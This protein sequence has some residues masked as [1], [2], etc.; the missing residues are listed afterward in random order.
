MRA[1]RDFSIRR[2]LTT[3]SM[4][5][6][7]L[8]LL[9]AGAAFIGYDFHDARESKVLDLTT[10]ANVLGSNSAAALVFNDASSAREMLR[11]LGA[12]P[13]VV[14]ACL[15]APSGR[16][17]AV[18]TRR[19]TAAA[20][21]WPPIGPEGARF[22]D[23]YL[24]FFHRITL[25]LETVGTIYLEE[26]SQDLRDRLA[27][28]T[29]V[30]GVVLL[31]ASFGAFLL[32]SK[33][34]Q[35]ISAPIQD[36]ARTTR[37][38]STEKNY[39]VRASKQGEDE[40]GLLIEGFN[41]MLEQIQRR[42]AELQDARDSLERRVKDRTAELQSQIAERQRAEE[43]LR[44]SD[45]RTR[46]LLDS[47]G[48]G[49]YGLDTHGNCTFCNPACVRTLG[50][51]NAGEL[52]GRN[53]HTLIHHSRPGGASLPEQDCR[54]SS[55][56]RRG[57]G[58]HVD[59][60]V[61]WRADG[62]SFPVEY[63]SHPIRRSSM[64]VGAVVT[65]TD[66]TERKRAEQHRAL[67]HSVAGILAASPSVDVAIPEI[68]KALCT[69]TG[70]E[71]GALFTLDPSGEALRPV[72]HWSTDERLGADFSEEAKPLLVPRGTGLAGRAW[73]SGEAVWAGDLREVRDLARPDSRERLGL[74]AAL[75]FPIFAQNRVTGVLEFFSRV[76]SERD[77]EVIGVMGGLGSQVGQFL[78]RKAAESQLE[79]AKE[80]AEA[81][82]RAK[83]EFLANMS[84]EI[85]TPMN[86]VLGLTELLLD[87]DLRPDQREYLTLVQSS[88]ESLL[89]IINDVLDFSKI[90]AG[91]ID[92]DRIEFNLRDS[93]ADVLKTLAVRAHKKG[94]ELSFRVAPDL[95]ERV[96]GDPLRLRQIIINLVGNAIKFTEHGEVNLSVDP[97]SAA[98]G[99]VRLHWVVSDTGIGISPQQQKTIFEPFTQADSS[100]TRRYGGT[101]LGLTISDRL[102]RMMDGGLWVESALGQGSRFHFTLVL[103]CAADPA[104]APFPAE[105]H[106][107]EN[108]PVLVVDDNG[109]NRLILDEMLTRAGF[110]VILADGGR[111]ALALLKAARDEGKP[112]P[113]ILLDGHMPEMDGF[114]V[115]AEIRC[116]LGLTGATI[117]M[118]TS[119]QQAADFL[120]CRELGIADCLTKPIGQ[121]D[122]FEAIQRVLNSS[123][124]RS[125][126]TPRRT[127]LP[128]AAPAERLH[129]LL[130]EDNTVN[131]EYASRL[132]EKYGHRVTAAVNGREVLAVLGKDGFGAFDA[133]L[134]DVQMPEMDGL[135]ATAAIRERERNQGGHLPIIAM[136]AHALKGDRERCLAAGMDGY[137][138]KPV[139]ADMLFKELEA[140]IRHAESAPAQ[141]AAP[142]PS[143]PSGP[144][145]LDRAAVLTLV[146][147]DRQLLEQLVSIFLDEVPTQLAGLK[148]AIGDGDAPRVE[149]LAHT[150]KG[151]IS[152]FAASSAWEAAR[153]LETLGREKNLAG[154]EAALTSLGQE[155]ERLKPALQALAQEVPS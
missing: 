88:A 134:M 25:Q 112:I 30:L 6:T 92:L 34:Q 58:A 29:G 86:G 50:Y 148:Q 45:E 89:Q 136:T 125:A 149:R 66:I 132:L 138:S 59:D 98:D 36:L 56:F 119:D 121:R 1:F 57:E 110:K 75:A 84:H 139:R 108:L 137:V 24:D 39:S 114:A 124:P 144:M 152:N 76:A 135:E 65:F 53:L 106:C 31:L 18:Y 8:A 17:F 154:A 37:T 51:R 27:R 147:G 145:L 13:Q 122:L 70:W 79:Q 63:R 2:K 107:L 87:T 126:E 128:K 93:V 26:D 151:A 16:V 47:T 43:A 61:Y 68:L 33:L 81:A 104:M 109:T 153:R 48:E 117:M 91:K 123:K 77:E 94:L 22:H 5:T 69:G 41:E 129:V 95:P 115:A 150:L 3:I 118:L 42:D 10:I 55:A 40:L 4:V 102:I 11:A 46:L 21:G 85:R 100:T 131:R 127:A 38:V 32:A 19:N 99:R 97:D 72:S 62:S 141:P 9:A 44:N 60:E 20:S 103:D 101:G 96:A 54:I 7:V 74:I 142:A 35:V 49:I 155:V 105:L 143:E 146:E 90:E 80:A 116:G 140:H 113:L 14:R 28:S 73:Q 111:A 82:S 15:Y 64:V 130:A 120:R 12:K 83:S 133:V 67:Q 23:G 52:L 78:A 71:L